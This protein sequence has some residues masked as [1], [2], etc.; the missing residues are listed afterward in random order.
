MRVVIRSAGVV[1]IEIVAAVLLAITTMTSA[2]AATALMVGGILAS[3]LPD[4][5]MS[6]VLNG[7]YTGKDEVSGTAWVRKNVPWSGSPNLGE[8]IPQATNNL[9]DLILTTPGPKTVVG[10]S[11]GSL[12]VEEVLRRL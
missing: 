3:D 10:M 4:S 7:A 11:A 2:L 12:A 1:V 9:Y 6:R 8:S 5:M